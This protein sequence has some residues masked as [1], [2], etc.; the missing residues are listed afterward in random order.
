VKEGRK[1]ANEVKEA[2]EV[3]TSFLPSTRFPSFFH[4][5]LSFLVKVL[6]AE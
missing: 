2:K 4:F 1:E 5:L 6:M 3:N